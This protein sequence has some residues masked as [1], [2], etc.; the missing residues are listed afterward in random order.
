MAIILRG[1]SKCVLCER[2]L[3]EGQ[4]VIGFPAFVT[5]E[6]DPLLI[7]HDSGVHS[8]CLLSNPLAKEAVNRVNEAEERT[9]PGNRYCRVCKKEILDPDEYYSVG[10]LTSDQ[11]DP[12][13]Q[14]NYS[15]F[16][17]QCIP[18]WTDLEQFRG[19][20]DA[21]RLS[22]KWKGRGLD[23]LLSDLGKCV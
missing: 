2:L 21:M 12:L 7:F 4:E 20:V 22:G 23:Y 5:N 13:N 6:A 11:T 16:H 3:E 8:D 17:K 10:H 14:Y 15:Q 9:G 1:K 18:K 19:L